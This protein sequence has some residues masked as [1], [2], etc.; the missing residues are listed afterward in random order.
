MSLHGADGGTVPK[1][2]NVLGAIPSVISDRI[3]VRDPVPL[4]EAYGNLAENIWPVPT[5]KLAGVPMTE[6]PVS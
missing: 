1:T 2:E 6:P 4:A 5:V 3:T